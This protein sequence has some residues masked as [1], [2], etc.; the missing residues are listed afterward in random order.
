MNVKIKGLNDD[1]VEVKSNYIKTGVWCVAKWKLSLW[2]ERKKRRAV[3]WVLKSD[4]SNTGENNSCWRLN[5]ISYSRA[6]LWGTEIV[7]WELR[8]DLLITYRAKK[9]Y[10]VLKAHQWEYNSLEAFWYL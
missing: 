10:W 2:L 8:T 1:M 3:T 5:E 4:T 7:L 9:P 6:G